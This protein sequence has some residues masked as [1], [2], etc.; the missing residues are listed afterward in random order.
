MKKKYIVPTST[1]IEFSP[2]SIIAMSFGGETDEVWTKKKDN[3][4]NIWGSN[5]EEEKGGIW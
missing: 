5:Q 3:S 2:E 4:S 1:S